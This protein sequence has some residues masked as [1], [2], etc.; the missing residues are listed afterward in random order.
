VAI[1]SIST[2]QSGLVKPATKIKVLAG[3]APQHAIVHVRALDRSARWIMK[4][5]TFDKIARPHARRLEHAQHLAPS[6]SICASVPAGT[7]PSGVTPTWPEMCSQRAL[8]G[9]AMAW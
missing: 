6:C 8:A 3:S 7:L 9:A 1:A 5:V 4:V 2:S